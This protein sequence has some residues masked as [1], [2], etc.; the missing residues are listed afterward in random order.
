MEEST[1]GKCQFERYF[2]SSHL[3]SML[4]IGNFFMERYVV[5]NNTVI[6]DN[7]EGDRFRLK[8]NE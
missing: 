5:K 6:E 8:G 2:V 1:K 7:M 4:T 3:N